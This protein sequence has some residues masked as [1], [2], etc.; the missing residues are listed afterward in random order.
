M[1]AWLTPTRERRQTHT[2]G[3]RWPPRGST[4]HPTEEQVE[5]GGRELAPG[6]ANLRWQVLRGSSRGPAAALLL[7]RRQGQTE[8]ALRRGLLTEGTH[9]EM[10]LSEEGTEQINTTSKGQKEKDMSSL[11][12]RGERFRTNTCLDSKKLKG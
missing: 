9:A 10:P 2:A 1:Q 5:A 8:S 6:Q 3:P 4:S 7:G 12:R 11:Q